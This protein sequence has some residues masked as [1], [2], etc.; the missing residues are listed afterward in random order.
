MFR[1]IVKLIFDGDIIVEHLLLPGADHLYP[2]DHI[3]AGS[4]GRLVGEEDRDPGDIHLMAVG[5]TDSEQEV[6]TSVI[7]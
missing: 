2:V 3:V 4:A 7:D 6:L 1:S 5:S